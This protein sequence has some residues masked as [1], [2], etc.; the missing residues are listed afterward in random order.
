MRKGD[1]EEAQL[2]R[3]CFL[4]LEARTRSGQVFK[5]VGTLQWVQEPVPGCLDCSEETGQK[6]R[7]ILT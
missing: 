2:E 5:G 3:A 4:G 6:H 7:I 1:A